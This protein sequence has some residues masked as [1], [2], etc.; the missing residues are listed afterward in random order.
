[1]SELFVIV[2]GGKYLRRNG[3]VATIKEDF[4]VHHEAYTD[5]RY[6]CQEGHTYSERG[7]YYKK[8]VHPLDLIQPVELVCESNSICLQIDIRG[9]KRAPSWVTLEHMIRSM[10]DVPEN[11][12]SLTRIHKR[13]SRPDQVG[14]SGDYASPGVYELTLTTI[15][16]SCSGFVKNVK[17][18][19]IVLDFSTGE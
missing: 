15:A 16:Q 7:N 6:L 13:G 9:G 8:M 14:G 1:M 4:G 10:L 12:G 17:M 3:T 19:H 5:E 11:C 2:V 18:F